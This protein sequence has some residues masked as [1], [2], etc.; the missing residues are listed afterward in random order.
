VRDGIAVI[1]LPSDRFFSLETASTQYF[2]D[3]AH[4]RGA[5]NVGDRAFD[6]S[7]ASV[8]RQ[9]A[10][11]L[12]SVIE[13][14][15][16]ESGILAAAEIYK[17]RKCQLV[18][19]NPQI[20]D[21]SDSFWRD[22]FPDLNLE[23]LPRTAYCHRDASG[24]DLKAI[25][26]MTDVGPNNGPFSFAI[27]SH[28]LSV[29]RIDDWIG[30]SN[31]MSGLSGTE[32]SARRKFAALPAKLRQKCAYGNDLVDSS[33]VAD[34]LDKSLWPITASK[35]ALVLFDTKGTHRGGM[36][37]EGERRVITCIIG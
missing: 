32:P 18:D 24:G 13:Q 19:V 11:A 9:S 21:I 35:G 26:Y 31:D 23:T 29:S 28:Q 14:V 5:S 25:I 8:G 1:A 22:I 16:E 3:L 12:F 7:R 2:A 6:E 34:A 30:E 17:G 36:V 27:G 37:V 33:P 4:R 10:S 15:L 20:N